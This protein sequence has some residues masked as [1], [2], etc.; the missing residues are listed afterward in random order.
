VKFEVE[1]IA[2]LAGKDEELNKAL[3][4]DEETKMP[5]IFQ[6]VYQ[7]V[8][9][10]MYLFSTVLDAP[11]PPHDLLGS[12]KNVAQN[13]GVSVEMGAEAPPVEAEKATAVSAEEPKT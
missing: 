5:H 2:T 3:E 13:E 11:P 6:R 7:Q 1:G 8:F 4:T 10:A 12:Y 9:T